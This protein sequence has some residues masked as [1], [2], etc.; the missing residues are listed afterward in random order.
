M[1][2]VVCSCC[3]LQSFIPILINRYQDTELSFLP[4]LLSGPTSVTAQPGDSVSLP[5]EVRPGV[6]RPQ[7]LLRTSTSI[8]TRD[9]P[10]RHNVS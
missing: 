8:L 2:P 9:T 3:L 4:E 10:Q 7:Y 6:R 1:S 5:C